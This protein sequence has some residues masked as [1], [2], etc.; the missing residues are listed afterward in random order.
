MLCLLLDSLC[1]LGHLDEEL[2]L[3]WFNEIFSLHCVQDEPVILLMDHDDS[4]VAYELKRTAKPKQVRN[5]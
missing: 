2:V 4:H 5:S 1:S 3:R